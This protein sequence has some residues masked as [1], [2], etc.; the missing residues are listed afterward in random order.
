MFRK[1]LF[2]YLID[3]LI[4][5]LIISFVGSFIPVSQNVT[6]LNA[7]LNDIGNSF[8]DKNIDLNTYINQYSVIGYSLEKELFLSS[9]LGVIINILY[10]VVYPF[11]NGG[12]S[13]G[14]KYMG[15]KVVSND[16]D[17][18]SSNQLLFRY[19]LMNSIGCSIIILCLIFVIKDSFYVY[20]DLI[21][22]ILQF[23]VVICSIFMVLYR[24]DK[25]SLPDLIAGTKVIEVKK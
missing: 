11:Y 9:L 1:R 14:K 7:Q 10:F 17:S 19:L 20:V 23:I 4:V 3:V 22:A 8:F 21:L 24:N 2:A 6:N 16:L 12:Q 18:V 5:F 15:I 13:I 25:R